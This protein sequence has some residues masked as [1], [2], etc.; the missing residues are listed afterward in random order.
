[1]PAFIAILAQKRQAVLDQWLGLVLDT[2][3][4]E[5]AAL[6]KKKKDPFAN[7]V[8]YRF[9]IGLKGILD[10]LLAGAAIPDPAVFAP[11]LDEIVRVRA[12]QDFTPAQATSFMFLLKKVVR[13][14]LWEELHQ[15]GD[16]V[17]LLAFESTVDILA[18]LAFDIYTSCREKIFEIRI[19]QTKLQ[20]DRLLKRSGLVCDFSTEGPETPDL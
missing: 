1:M 15:G 16:W 20:Y 11:F 2:Y 13:E 9:E 19:N 8:R 17:G 7:P 14:L 4:P 12:V 18:L 6:W 3:A 10:G 5:T